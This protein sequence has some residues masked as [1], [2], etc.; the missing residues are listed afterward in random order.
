MFVVLRRSPAGRWKPLQVVDDPTDV[1]SVLRH[2]PDACELTVALA[3]IVLSVDVPGE[4][5]SREAADVFEEILR[6]ITPPDVLRR[7]DDARRG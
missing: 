5:L 2:F 6:E 4:S 7:M 1:A 3:E